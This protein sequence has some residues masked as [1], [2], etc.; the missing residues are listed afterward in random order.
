MSLEMEQRQRTLVVQARLKAI[1]PYIQSLLEAHD[2]KDW[3]DAAVRREQLRRPDKHI[4]RDS[5]GD[6]RYLARLIAFDEVA[7]EPFT[8]SDRAGARAL[9]GIFNDLAHDDVEDRPWRTGS[10]QRA[11]QIVERLMVA[12]GCD[13]GQAPQQ[14]HTSTPTSLGGAR[15]DA[16]V[17]FDTDERELQECMG[18]LHLA[19]DEKVLLQR[20]L[21]ECMGELHLAHDEREFE[22]C[23]GEL[24]LAHDEQVLLERELQ[25]RT[26]ELHLAHDEQVLLQ[27]ELQ[28]CTGE[29]H[30]AHDEQVLLER[31]LQECTPR[32]AG[33]R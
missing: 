7:G 17:A 28:E 4:G 25:E 8:E 16:G 24:H 27:R 5:I 10:D 2:G 18:E 1:G 11:K 21:Y 19:H 6:P 23:M 32:T 3:R 33:E 20:E 29:L 13:G 30:L 9:T 12:A 31:K 14:R 15:V 26:G 22:E